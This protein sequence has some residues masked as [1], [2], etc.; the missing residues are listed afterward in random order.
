MSL[1]TVAR[2]VFCFVLGAMLAY[3]QASG[4][5]TTII[6]VGPP[7]PVQGINAWTVGVSGQT[8]YYYWV[9]A[10][11]PRGNVVPLNGPVVIYTAN[12]TL[13]GGNYVQLAWSAQ[14]GVRGYAVLRN[15][16]PVFPGTGTTAVIAYTTATTVNDISNT[17]IAY[18]HVPVGTSILELSVNNRDTLVPTM[19]IRLDGTL[20]NSSLGTMDGWVKYNLLKIANTTFSCATA[21]GCWVVNG[22][23]P[24]PAVA[25]L[26]QDLTLFT[27]PANSYVSRVRMK[28]KTACTGATTATSGLG[29]TG[30]VA[31]FIAATDIMAAPGATNLIDTPT[32]GGGTT[33]AAIAILASLTTTGTNIDTLVAGCSV[34]YW[35]KWVTLP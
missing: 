13:S 27:L 3:G 9:V 20:I 30:T 10:I 14:I 7:S 8:T 35:V 11:Y 26:T 33:A 17:L 19:Q 23:T 25:A 31:Y 12:G 24:V 2:V 5:D 34:D 1:Q 16:T 29:I 18:T 22:G 21:A 4:V 32:P 6:K 15:T 28:P